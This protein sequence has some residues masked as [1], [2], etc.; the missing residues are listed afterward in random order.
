MDVPYFHYILWGVQLPEK[1]V[2]A[3]LCWFEFDC[4]WNVSHSM[5]YFL[6]SK[7]LMK[8]NLNRPLLTNQLTSFKWRSAR[9]LILMQYTIL[10]V[11]VTAICRF[12]SCEHNNFERQELKQRE[13]N[14]CICFMKR[15][16]CQC[17]IYSNQLNHL[18]LMRYILL[19]S[20]WH[21]HHSSIKRS[22]KHMM[23]KYN[24]T[25]IL[26]CLDFW[27]TVNYYT[28]GICRS[29][30]TWIAPFLIT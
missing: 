19:I 30:W 23:D 10:S 13:T 18:V 15:K 17:G 3:S 11:A 6:F 14:K 4:I 26:S 28:I 5:P 2:R 7:R 27:T 12:V 24:W 1:R 20:W 8:F 21:C 22:T 29:H 25:N 16:I 9:L